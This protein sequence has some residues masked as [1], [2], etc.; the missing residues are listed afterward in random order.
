MSRLGK[1]SIAIPSG[2]EVKVTPGV[3]EVKG[4][5][6]SLSFS[7]NN[8]LISIAVQDNGVVLVPTT[9]TLL[10]KKLWG[11]YASHV[12]NLLVGVLTPYQK[13]LV[14]EGVGFKADVQ[15]ATLGLSL[16]FSHPVK[17]PIPSGL[18]VTADKNVI[19]ISGISKE[20][21]AEF[22]AQVRALK[23]PEPY[24]GKGIRYQNEVILR[25]EGKKAA[26]V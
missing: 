11:T 6:G 8:E 19:S 7:F 23:K 24:K 5:L 13:T 2:V 4:P 9:E 12:K 21:V 15:G 1:K 18:K 16:G 26:S 20:G 22:A 10:S 25:K 17:V 3:V 14:I